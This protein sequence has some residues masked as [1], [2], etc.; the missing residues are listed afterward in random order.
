MILTI[1]AI[2]LLSLLNGVTAAT[3][4]LTVSVNF[5]PKPLSNE[6]VTV[7]VPTP[8]ATNILPITPTILVLEDVI[9]NSPDFKASLTLRAGEDSIATCLLASPTCHSADKSSLFVI[10]TEVYL[11]VTSE[12]VGATDVG[13]DVLSHEATPKPSK[14]TKAID[15]NVP[16]FI[17]SS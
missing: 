6:I 5:V 11:A 4:R 8:L 15:N 13:L 1:S 9:V 3:V 17:F 14:P 2:V 16:F 10:A 12:V 7:A